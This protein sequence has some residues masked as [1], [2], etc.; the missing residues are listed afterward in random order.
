LHRESGRWTYDCITHTIGQMTATLEA[1]LHIDSWN[2]NPYRELENGTKFTR[3]EVALAADGP[4]PGDGLTEAAFEGLMFYRPD[5]T[6][7]FVVVMYATANLAGRNGT[8]VLSG[9][10]AYDGQQAQM[11]LRV[12]EGSGTGDLVGLSGSLRSSST[13]ADYPDMPLTLSY[14]LP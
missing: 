8:F 5:G 11:A 1:K 9:D 4:S 13:H 6:S 10:G 12:I 3:A 7:H 14:D 2:E